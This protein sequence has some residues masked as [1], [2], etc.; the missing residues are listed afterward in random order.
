[1]IATCRT[2][3]HTKTQLAMREHTEIKV[4]GMHSKIRDQD[5]GGLFQSFPRFSAPIWKSPRVFFLIVA[6]LL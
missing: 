4:C 3:R 1:M 2:D 6:F 5:M